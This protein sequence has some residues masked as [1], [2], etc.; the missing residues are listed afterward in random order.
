MIVG[1]FEAFISLVELHTHRKDFDSFRVPMGLVP[2][3]ISNNVR[4]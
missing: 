2:A 4:V 1:G 3:T